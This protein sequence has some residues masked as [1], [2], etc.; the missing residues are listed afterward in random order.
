[1]SEKVQNFWA[2]FFLLES[3]N[4]GKPVNIYFSIKLYLCTNFVYDILKVICK[5][6]SYITT[7]NKLTAIL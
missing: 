2:F 4:I 6:C 3:E 7:S 1:M 5:Y